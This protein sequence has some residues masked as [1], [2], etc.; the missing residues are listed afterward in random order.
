MKILLLLSI[1]LI[2]DG[3]NKAFGLPFLVNPSLT[4]S[5]VKEIFAS[6]FSTDAAS[7]FTYFRALAVVNQLII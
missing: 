3:T 5:T 6:D 2:Y 1:Y 7:C 4:K